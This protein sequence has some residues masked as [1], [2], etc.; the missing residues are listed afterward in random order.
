MDVRLYQDPL[1]DEKLMMEGPIIAQEEIEVQEGD[2]LTLVFDETKDK[3]S[4]IAPNLDTTSL[5][6]FS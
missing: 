6:P 1:F 2:N 4:L 3:S 5:D